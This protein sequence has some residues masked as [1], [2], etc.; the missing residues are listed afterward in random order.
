MALQVMQV[1]KKNIYFYVITSNL[2]ECINKLISCFD[3]VKRYDNN[4][5]KKSSRV[6]PSS[7]DGWTD[8]ILFTLTF[9]MM[10]HFLKEDIG[11]LATNL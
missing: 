6:Y 11:A 8:M 3:Q 4:N 1:I 5:K 9:Y 2:H 7:V 10:D